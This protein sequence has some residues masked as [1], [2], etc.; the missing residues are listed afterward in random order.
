M[1]F[2]APSNKTTGTVVT[3]AHWNQDVVENVNALFPDAAGAISWTPGLGSHVG[4]GAAVTTIG[5]RYRVGA[6]QH[7]WARF[8]ITSPGAGFYVVALP[9]AA[10]GVSASAAQGSGQTIGSWTLRDDSG[11]DSRD[12]TVLLRAADE[13][14]FNVGPGNLTESY[15]FLIAAG[16]ILSFHASYPIA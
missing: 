7:V 8:T 6:I 10:V 1:A 2:I 11:P 13:V 5:R 3:A 16:D 9:V 14:W 15:P 12:G 4:T